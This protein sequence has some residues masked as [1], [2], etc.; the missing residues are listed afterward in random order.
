M[1]L[2]R[3]EEAAKFLRLS[4]STLARWRCTGNGPR[5]IKLGGSILYRPE[6]LQAFIEQRVRKNTCE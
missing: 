6:D 1:E 2:L 3:P 5:F 4:A